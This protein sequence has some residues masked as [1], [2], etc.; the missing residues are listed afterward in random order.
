VTSALER[1]RDWT[2]PAT[3]GVIDKANGQDPFVVS[4]EGDPAAAFRWASVTKVLTAIAIWIAAEEGTVSWDDPVGP[5]GA[6]LA[7]L[8]SHSS[9]IA[10]DDD[11]VLARPGARRIYS[12]RGI[13]LAALHL[14][15]RAGMPFAEYL[16]LGLLN[17]LGLEGVRLDGSPAHGATGTLR[18][19][20]LVGEEL[21]QPTLISRE[22][23]A[24]CT[25]VTI[26]GLAGVL[27]GF[28]RQEHNDWGLGVEIRDHKRPHWTGDRNSPSAFG[29]FGQ[30][31]CFL[32]VD[33]ELGLALGVLSGRDFG[34]W[35]AEAWPELSDAV[36]SEYAGL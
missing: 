7:H 30:T 13:E 15:D 20:L 26:P 18:D 2:A 27:P 23:L 3:A 25:R 21:L 22:T 35:A 36:I 1:L 31:G 34:P 29:H 5:P 32:W 11:R 10:P 4:S 19:L 12:N 33:P 28:G 6:T 8:M 17:P 9:G 14:A 24:A 16:A